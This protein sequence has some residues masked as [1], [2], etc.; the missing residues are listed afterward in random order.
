VWSGCPTGPMGLCVDDSG[1]YPFHIKFAR[2]RMQHPDNKLDT[3]YP[4]GRCYRRM[5]DRAYYVPRT[6]GE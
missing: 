4:L 1:G 2:G 6:D 3:I 5:R